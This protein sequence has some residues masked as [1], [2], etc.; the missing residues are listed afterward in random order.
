MEP[1]FASPTVPS[2]VS[3]IPAADKLPLPV[4]PSARPWQL[5]ESPPAHARGGHRAKQVRGSDRDPVGAIL[6]AL[7]I[8]GHVAVVTLLG[9]SVT[10]PVRADSSGP[11]PLHTSSMPDLPHA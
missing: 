7:F 6:A 3:R 1:A 8:T 5:V 4:A 2:V 9:Y 11:G 10:H